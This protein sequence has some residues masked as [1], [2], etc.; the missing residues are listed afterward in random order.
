MANSS[1]QSR[2]HKQFLSR[3]GEDHST[4][5][6]SGSPPGPAEQEKHS[7][8]TRLSQMTGRRNTKYCLIEKTN[9]IDT[10]LGLSQ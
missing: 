7:E 4:D 10:W 8:K 5:A 1:P 3:S 2:F 9:K 6:T